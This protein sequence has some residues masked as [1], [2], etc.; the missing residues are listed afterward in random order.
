V[1]EFNNP[2]LEKKQPQNNA[3]HNKQSLNSETTMLLCQPTTT[4][5]SLLKRASTT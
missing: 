2:G 1:F 5:L 4:F 3:A